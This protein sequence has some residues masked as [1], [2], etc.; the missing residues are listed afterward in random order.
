VMEIPAIEERH[1]RAGIEQN[2]GSHR[3]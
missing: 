1:Q 3:P 2:P